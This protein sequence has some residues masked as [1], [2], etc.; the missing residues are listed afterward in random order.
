MRHFYNSTAFSVVALTWAV[1]CS[2]SGTGA[3]LPSGG[4]STPAATSSPAGGSA[5]ASPSA[6]GTAADPAPAPASCAYDAT[7]GAPPAAFTTSCASCHGATGEGKGAYPAIRGSAEIAKIVRSGRTS[8]T[9]TLTTAEGNSL[10]AQMPAFS[11]AHLSEVDLATIMQYLAAP[12]NPS[13]AAVPYCLS[14]PEASWTPDQVDEAYQRGLRAWRTTGEVD[15]NACVFCHGPDAIEFA[16][17]GYSDAQIYRRAFSH[18]SQ[19]VA[20]DVVD[21]VHALRARYNIVSPPDPLVARPFQ[22][23][24]SVLPGSTASE[25]DAAFGQELQDMKLTLMGPP[26]NSAAD[27]H[28]AY[29]E[30]KALNLRTLRVGIPM[31]RY[32]EDIFNNAG[33][34]PTCPDKHLC[35]DHGTIADWISDVP[36]LTADT[37]SAL[38]PLHDAYLKDPTLD[39]LKKVLLAAPR[40]DVSWFK[41]KYLAVQMANF[42]F[43][44][45]VA[46]MPMLD[47]LPDTPFPVEGGTLFNSIWMVGANLRDFIHNVGA[48]L[49]TG[50]GKF[51][52]PAATLPGLTRNDASEQLQRA[53]VPWFWLGFSFDPSTMNVEADY[54]AEGD[55]YFT[56]QTFVDSGSSPI[57]AAF[58]VSKRSIAMMSYATLPRS[59]NVFPFNHPDLGRFPVTP[60]SMRSGYFPVLTNFAEEKN[61]NT[62][63]NYQLDKMPTEPKQLALFQTYTANMYRMFLWVLIDEL[64][65]TPQI[66]NPKILEGKIHKAEL[67]LTSTKVTNA[68][69]TQ[70]TAMLAQAR[71]LA[72]K[73]TVMQ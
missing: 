23:G 71:Q 50:G 22:P 27:A 24:G 38:Y 58:I 39:N 19:Q 17:I 51:A 68:N 9:I 29:D 4:S 11:A 28:K 60:L 12:L 62:I 72:A 18:V 37:A 63:N 7:L 66:W 46:G 6:G 35:D 10:P 34:A 53:I 70:D 32:T 61:F 45:Q 1:G 42:L 44:Q 52:V 56:Q 14:R 41:N 59:P 33:Q 31:N 26:I 8:T 54:V 67:F 64:Q 3:P 43:R 16:A 40:D 55:E 48:T 69:L 20:D 13:P 30:L 25:R 49:P 5:A 47:A 73:A 2:S 36:V 57:H 21:M 15:K 65:Q